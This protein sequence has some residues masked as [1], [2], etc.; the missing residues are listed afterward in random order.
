MK[1]IIKKKRAARNV[2]LVKCKHTE[3]YFTLNVKYLHVATLFFLEI[4][5]YMYF[6]FFQVRNLGIPEKYLSIISTTNI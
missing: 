1:K 4:V 5:M 2:K 6:Y 3:L